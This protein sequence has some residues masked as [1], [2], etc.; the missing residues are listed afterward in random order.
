MITCYSFLFTTIHR[1]YK[2]NIIFE[3]PFDKER[4][5]AVVEACALKP[6]FRALEDGDM[7][8]IGAKGVSLSGGQKAR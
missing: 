6:D 3:Y 7:T 4:Y 2:N 8:E 5:D 1:D